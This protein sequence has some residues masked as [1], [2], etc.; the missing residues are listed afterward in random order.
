MQPKTTNIE[1]LGFGRYRYV[2]TKA[3]APTKGR[4]ALMGPAT[5]VAAPKTEPKRNRALLDMAEGRSCLLR[6]P[7]ICCDG[8]TVACHSNLSIHG[9]AGARKADDQYSVFGCATCHRWLDQ[10]PASASRKQ[11][12]FMAAHVRQVDQWRIIAADKSEPYRL[13]QA[14]LWALIQLN[15]S[16]PFS[17]EEAP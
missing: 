10:G 5:T 17:L 11:A 15:S 16:Q 12:V 3:A 7:G 14:A 1:R 8:H 2:P 4:M 13:Q 6:V 9:K